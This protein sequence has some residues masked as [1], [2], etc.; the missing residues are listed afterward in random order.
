MRSAVPLVEIVITGGPAAGKTAGIEHVR[1]RLLRDGWSCYAVPE[2]ATMMHRCAL[3]ELMAAAD[4][5]DSELADEIQVQI[6][7]WQDALRTR[8]RALARAVHDGPV[9]ILYDRAEPDGRAYMRA[10]AYRRALR[11]IGL[12]EHE[13]HVR[14]PAV[15]HL[16]SCAADH[17]DAYR[18]A[19]NPARRESVVEAVSSDA[20]TLAAWD[21]HLRRTVVDSQRR[22]PDKLEQLH[23][24][25]VAETERQLSAGRGRAMLEPVRAKSSP[26]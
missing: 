23:E 8:T 25:I 17:P 5:G 1:G 13:A 11:L 4:V 18:E 7:A 15:V 3:G 9:I 24:L 6:I 26:T 14:Y 19:V 16:R 20:R 10:D 22:F 21:G 2:A 12:D